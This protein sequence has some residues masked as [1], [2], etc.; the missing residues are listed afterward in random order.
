MNRAE[1]PTDEELKHNLAI[2]QMKKVNAAK[3]DAKYSGGKEKE[4]QL[5][6]GSGSFPRYDEYETVAGKGPKNPE[7]TTHSKKLGE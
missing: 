4:P 5:A 7:D 3:L 6:T 1:P 2:M